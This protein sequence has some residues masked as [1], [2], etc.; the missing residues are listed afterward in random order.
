MPVGLSE[1]EAT[2][3]PFSVV[4]DTNILVADFGWRSAPLQTSGSSSDAGQYPACSSRLVIQETANKYAER[5][6]KAFGQMSSA[7]VS[8]VM[9]HE[10]GHL[11]TF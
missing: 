5:V 1:S 3:E 11:D 8:L 4:L 10:L 7:M 2:G 9:A 6:V